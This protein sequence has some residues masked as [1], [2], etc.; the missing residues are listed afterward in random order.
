M[1]STCCESLYLVSGNL[2]SD[3]HIWMRMT[4][5]DSTR[6]ES[7]DACTAVQGIGRL[8]ISIIRGIGLESGSG[9]SVLRHLPNTTDRLETG[10]ET[11]CPFQTWIGCD[12]SHHEESLVYN[13]IFAR[14]L[15]LLLLGLCQIIKVGCVQPRG[16]DGWFSNLKK[17][18]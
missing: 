8:D 15:R 7:C 13:R 12:Q 14:L 4:S 17:L 9:P 11:V 2:Q 6:V 10:H 1:A 5:P 18:C 16:L 3:N